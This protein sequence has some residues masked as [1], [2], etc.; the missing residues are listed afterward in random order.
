MVA[1]VIK[2]NKVEVYKDGH[3]VMTIFHDGESEIFNTPNYSFVSLGGFAR[4]YP[5][6]IVDEREAKVLVKEVK[7][8][9]RE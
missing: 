6:E 3:F 2:E 5:D 9:T 4:V 8:G 1:A 7:D